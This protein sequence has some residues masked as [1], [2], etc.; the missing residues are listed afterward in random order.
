M[1]SIQDGNAMKTRC[2]TVEKHEDSGL[3]E[4]FGVADSTLDSWDA[5][6]SRSV[7]ILSRTARRC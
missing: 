2:L 4:R 7:L 5:V 1:L 6:S 3:S